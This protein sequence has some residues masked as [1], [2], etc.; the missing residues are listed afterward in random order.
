M[1]AP[2]PMPRARG[3]TRAIG[4]LAV[5]LLPLLAVAL[6]RLSP[7]VAFGAEGGL[8]GWLAVVVPGAA[9]AMLAMAT[10][11]L[12]GAAIATTGAS[13]AT[14]AVAT[15]TLAL[16]LGLDALDATQ[17][18]HAQPGPGL[19]IAAAAAAVL[20]IIRVP[21]P[22]QAATTRGGRIGLGLAAFAV[23]EAELLA[24][25]FLA[26]AARDAAPWLL[27]AGAI[28]VAAAMLAS[29]AAPG[30]ER[31]PF[32]GALLIAGSL[33]ALALARPDSADLLPGALGLLGAGL[34][35][36][37]GGV[38][39]TIETSGEPPAR[40]PWV[41]GAE[42]GAVLESVVPEL[43][44]LPVRLLADTSS[45]RDDEERA[46]TE[47]EA[48]R[49]TRELRGTIEEL[50]QARRI[51]ELQRAEISRAATVDGLSGAASRRAILERLVTEV[52]QARRYSHP[53]AVLLLD[54]DEFR[55]I[56]ADRGLATGDVVLR[57]VGLRLRMRMRA[58]DALGRLGNDA[59][60]AILP[61]TDERGA[62]TFAN[63]LIRHVTGRPVATD[64][65]ELRLTVS[66][67]V[68]IMRPGMELSDELLLTAAE[69]AWAS[70]R[71]AG[72]NRVAFDR[73][74]GLARLDDR[75]PG[76]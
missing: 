76:R 55:A 26:D 49:L 57:E 66:I 5:A 7:P 8:P 52:A 69:E 53:V 17:P 13:T 65:G 4:R 1:A 9:A 72:G 32:P 34:V 16:G 31:R 73:L 21:L 23:L 37:R 3:T 36:A 67:G 46:R 30:L 20:L 45:A 14:G 29:W 58:A 6:L 27:A 2:Q 51:V 60:L 10:V 15:G 70:A 38:T 61:H 33:G 25:V 39:K 22:D 42:P 19:A 12:L 63:A 48:E 47:A 64:S 62:A 50:L 71:A 59:F 24:A 74:H 40:T 18:S 75:R 28:G 41:A 56:N 35:I 44:T 43:A 68:A 11:T 54:I